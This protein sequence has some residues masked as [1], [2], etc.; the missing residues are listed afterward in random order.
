M[1]KNDAMAAPAVAD[2][3]KY[4]ELWHTDHPGSFMEFCRFMTTPSQERE[5]WMSQYIDAGSYHWT[6]KDGI[7][8]ITLI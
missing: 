3:A 6:T 2:M 4:Y 5:E 1:K 7:A 8:T